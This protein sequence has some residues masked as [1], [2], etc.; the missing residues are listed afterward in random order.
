MAVVAVMVLITV[1]FLGGTVMALAVSSNLHT[2]DLITAQDAVHYAAESAVFVAW[3][4][5]T[6]TVHPAD[7]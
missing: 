3:R 1:L 7:R 6:I 2:V 4:P 5:A